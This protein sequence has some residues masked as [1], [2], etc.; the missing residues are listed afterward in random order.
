VQ[1]TKVKNLDFVFGSLH[2]FS[3]PS[4]VQFASLGLAVLDLALGELAIRTTDNEYLQLKAV[5]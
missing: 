2:C 3:I 5:L 4:I 1:G